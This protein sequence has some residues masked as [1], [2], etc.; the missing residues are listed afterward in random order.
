[1]KI[2]I[3]HHHA[4]FDG[5]A[6]M[7]GVRKLWP[8]HELV[9]GSSISPPVRKYLALHKDWLTVKSVG[10]LK[11][12][13]VSEVVVVDSRDSR[14]FTDFTKYLERA[15]S[16]TVFDHHPPSEHDIKATT[17]I[18]EPVGA[19]ATLLCERI[20]D[21]G[22]ELSAQEATLMMLGIYADTGSLSFPSTT[23]RDLRAAAFLLGQGASLP[24]VTRYLQ[25]EYSPS[26]RRLLVS[27]LDD[28]Q[29]IERQGLRLGYACTES[30][31][32]VKGAA[33]VV[34]RALKLTGLDALFA[35]SL[36][37]DRDAV[38]LIARSHTGHVD[39]A[40]MARKWGGGGHP[41][42]AAARTRD[43]AREEVVRQL[44]EHLSN[45]EIRPLE[46]RDVMS[47]PV[48]TVAP[49]ARLREVEP[50][51]Q[52]WA[53]SGVPVLDE[54]NLVG[55]VS[56]RDVDA[57]A[58]RGDWEIPVSGFMTHKVVTVEPGQALSEALEIMTEEDVGR[59]PVMNG[60]CLVGI[61]SRSDVLGRLYAAGEASLG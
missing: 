56:T 43:V 17:E 26:Q 42:A 3:T 55:I 48:Q 14:R 59:L 24:V 9:L 54:G 29:V 41:S 21:E 2:A 27:L 52:R 30:K 25:Q 20:E 8:D 1:M 31:S 28:I 5:L 57:A 51:L 35:V 6:S 53:V 16:L 40:Q 15:Q 18:V 58:R 4:D 45:L 34:E 61:V 37:L 47:C 49:D 23:I 33:Q 44:K 60:E 11:G 46:V 10:D 13:T 38:Q 39:A 12:E 19:C 22:V 50:L 7:L 36:V 32:Y